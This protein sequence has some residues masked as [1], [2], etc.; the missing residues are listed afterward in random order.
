M[1]PYQ[2]GVPKN[3]KSVKK[4]AKTQ[5]TSNHPWRKPFYFTTKDTSYKP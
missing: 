5:K 2:K 1:N 3:P 4:M